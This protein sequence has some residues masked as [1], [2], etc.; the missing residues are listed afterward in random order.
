MTNY[1][2]IMVRFGELSTKG[3]NKKVFIQ[4]L[5][6]Q[7]KWALK[8]FPQLTIQMRPDHIYITLNGEDSKEVAKRLQ[9]VSGIHSF[10]FVCKVALDLEVMKETALELLKEEQGKTFKVRAKRADKRF[11]I[12]SD[13]INRAIAGR[14]LSTTSWKVDVHHPDVLLSLTIREDAAYFFTN[15]IKGAGGYP[16]GVGGKAMMMMSGGIDSPVAAYLLMKRGV[17]IECIHFAAPPYTNAAVIDKIRDL[18]KKLN[19]YQRRITVHVVPFTEL[20]LEIYRQSG[21]SL[22]ITVMRRMMYRISEALAKKR[23]CYAM[24]NGESVGQVASQT[25]AS[26]RTIN[27][28]T[29][30]PVLRPLSIL[31]KLEIIEIARKIDTYDISIRP[32]EDCCTIF[33]PKNPK[34]APRID[35]VEEIEAKWDYASMVE[36]CVRQTTSFVVEEEEEG[37][38]YL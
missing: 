38:Q 22:A 1:E 33:D 19:R 25:L 35:E 21:E 7:I 24:A 29:S 2:Y 4:T 31:D 17:E 30:Y 9:D 15:S 18:C 37:N 5:L 28:V 13:D 16:L 34:T 8:G 6:K 23:S 36:D 27:A 11:P 26:M 12:H 14:I 20:Q 32:Y 3:K 10:S